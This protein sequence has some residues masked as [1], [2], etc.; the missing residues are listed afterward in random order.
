MEWA[1]KRKLQYFGI[2][3]LLIIIFVGLPLYFFVYQK[4]TCFD[5]IKNG[6]ELGVDCGGACRLLC[7]NQITEPI[8]RWDPRIFKVSEGNY[9]TLAY[10]DNPNVSGEVLHASYTFRLYD[11]KGVLITER[12]GQTFIPR[13]QQ[14]AIYEG[15]YSI[16]D[17]IPVRAT[18]SF[19]PNLV[20]ITNRTEEPTVKI[21][22]KAL[23]RLD[24]TPRVEAQIANDSLS[25]INNI[26]LTAIIFDGSGNAIGAS[27][28]LVEKLNAGD[29]KDVVFTWPTPF[30]TRAES[31]DVP[32]DVVILTDRSGSMA[33]IGK[34]PPQP[35]TD[36]KNAAISF[37][38]SLRE[39]DQAGF[40]SFAN[41]AS[42]DSVLTSD[43]NVL[44]KTIGDMSIA[45][46]GVQNTN[47]ADAFTKAYSELFSA[48]GNKDANKTIILLTDGIANVPE[49]IGDPKFAE[50]EAL[51]AANQLKDGK[52]SIFSIGLGK[53]LNTEFL[54]QIASSSSEF[55]LA[56]T[57]AQLNAIY[58]DIG[59]KICARRPASVEII[60]RVYP[61]DI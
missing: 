11:E 60:K 21:T 41:S 7:Q 35:L 38:S 6:S 40:I 57:T 1:T 13:G 20:W 61:K 24:S 39:H 4:P 22:S 10:L 37:V 51:R 46:N 27:R 2:I 25:E 45:T 55:F 56:P 18:F 42:V 29:K 28:T 44:K 3:A 15:S 16:A 19:D 8:L 47:I 54:K 30:V 26:E 32:V 43:F 14:F 53:D 52:V 17:R 49:K 5:G 33:S 58:K 12:K 59:T 34:D 31:C 48:R 50:S 36:V 23:S 9:S